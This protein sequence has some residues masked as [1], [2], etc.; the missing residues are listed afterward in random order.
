[1][2]QRETVSF[3]GIFFG[4]KLVRTGDIRSI[5]PIWQEFSIN[6]YNGLCKNAELCRIEVLVSVVR[7]KALNFPQHICYNTGHGRIKRQGS[8]IVQIGVMKT[9][10]GGKA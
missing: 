4:G 9:R 7:E 5:T 1:M 2:R 3:K 10:D 8:H 6:C